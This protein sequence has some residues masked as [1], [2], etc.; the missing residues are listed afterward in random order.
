LKF[1]GANDLIETFDISNIPSVRTCFGLSVRERPKS[2]SLKIFEEH[3]SLNEPLTEIYLPIPS[4]PDT[5]TI[6]DREMNSYEFASNSTLENERVSGSILMTITWGEH[7]RDNFQT[8]F[9]S[10]STHNSSFFDPLSSRGPVGLLNLPSLIEWVSKSKFD[11]NDPRNNELLALKEMIGSVCGIDS[12]NLNGT[13]FRWSNLAFFRAGLPHWLHWETL[14]V[15][16]EDTTPFEKRFEIL[17]KRFKNEILVANP[18]PL[19]I[20]EGLHES[21]ITPNFIRDE[22][23]GKALEKWSSRHFINNDENSGPENSFD[24]GFLK[25]IR[26]LQL[27]RKLSLKNPRTVDHY[28]KEERLPVIPDQNCAFW[29]LLKPFRPLNPYRTNINTMVPSQVDSCRLVVQILQC[30]NLPIRKSNYIRNESVIFRA[31]QE[32]I[33][34]C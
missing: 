5:N 15:G 4:D 31:N 20:V 13:L 24:L 30:F 6:M 21:F 26:E 29:T 19:H 2:I 8:E 9:G 28:V 33:S 1:T 17:T 16:P 23:E 25:R 22:V 18:V 12:G 27:I 11:P 14:G 34:I 32:N 3:T 7:P 10:R